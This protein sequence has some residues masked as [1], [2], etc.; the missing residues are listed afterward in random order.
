MATC[1]PPFGL[2][3]MLTSSG[4]V[5]VV[6]L[7]DLSDPPVLFCPA[8]V[9]TSSY[10]LSSSRRH[11][12]MK[13]RGGR[14][15]LILGAGLALLAFAVVYILTSKAGDTIAGSNGSPSQ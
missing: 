12:T 9:L 13:K 11:T 1:L 5:T 6:R 3:R 4:I 8:I 14:F 2:W 15:L 7:T 10:R